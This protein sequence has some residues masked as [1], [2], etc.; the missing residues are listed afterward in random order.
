MS[1]FIQLF[2]IIMLIKTLFSMFVITIQLAYLH[3]ESS[4]VWPQEGWIVELNRTTCRTSCSWNRPTS[5][6]Q[7]STAGSTVER[8]RHEN[9]ANKEG[10]GTNE[11]E[12]PSLF[13]IE[14]V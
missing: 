6:Y 1:L 2:I 7:T 3:C 5:I 11:R 12:S 8:N 10:M 14:L 13:L 9:G 4:L